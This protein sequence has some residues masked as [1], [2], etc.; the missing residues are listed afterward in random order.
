MKELKRLKEITDTLRNPGGC[1]WDQKQ[2]FLSMR[3]DLLEEV[4][5]LIDAVNHNDLEHIEEELGD[6]LFLVLF[7]AKLGEETGKFT[8]ESAAKNVG[9]K[10]IRRH[11]HVFSDTKINNV[12]DIL[13]NWEEIKKAEKGISKDDKSYLLN[14]HD[15]SFLPALKRAHKIQKKAARTGFDWPNITPALEKLDEEIDE[16]KQAIQN[17]T[18]KKNQDE[19]CDELGDV[20]FSVVNVARH[21]EQSP[22][23]CLH[24]TIEKFI[25]RFQYIEKNISVD[26]KKA[27]SLEAMDKLWNEAKKVERV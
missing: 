25:S 14:P 21:L 3:E 2:N 7:Y 18:D 22:E 6:V 1:E 8:L 16:L 26:D 20:L 11:P 17:H 15:Y 23:F 13:N 24:K 9:E 12:D 5:E 19:I 27:K 10:L 4:Y